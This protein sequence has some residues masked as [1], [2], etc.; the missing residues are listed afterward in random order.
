MQGFLEYLS[1][2]GRSKE[3]ISQ[4]KNDLKIAF[5]YLLNNCKNKSFIDI[6][7]RDIIKF[8]SF[9]L[10]NCGM[11]SARIKRLRCSLSSMSNYIENFLDDEYEDFR[12]II[13][14]IEAPTLVPVREKTIITF[15]DCERVA[16]SLIEDGNY[17]LACY[18]TVSCYS[19][20]RKKELT[21]LLVKDFTTDIH[22]TL[23]NSF[24]KTS[25]IKVKGKGNRV[26]EKYVWNK[27]DKWLKLWLEYRKKNN[28]EC[29]YLF[30]REINGQYKQLATT[31]LD[32]FATRLKKYFK[33]DFYNHST[34]HT[35]ASELTRAGLPIEVIQFLLGHRS[36]ETSKLYIDISDDENMEQFADFFSGKVDNYNK[37]S[38]SNL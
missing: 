31:T 17:Q 23:G 34:R 27:C 24:Y 19:G 26:Q 12:N 29:E 8:Q 28:I 15:E 36:S 20:L 7:K 16:D 2:V 6:K 1:S 5:V 10:N 4:Y 21:R 38:L 13:N 11:S 14:K 25:P 3:T 35:L 9:L 37:K 22:M 30:C 32:S 18:I 33:C